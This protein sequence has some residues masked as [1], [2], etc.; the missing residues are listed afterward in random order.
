MHHSIASVWFQPVYFHLICFLYWLQLADDTTPM[1]KSEE[2]EAER[3]AAE[4]KKEEDEKKKKEA[5]KD[6]DD[7]DSDSSEVSFT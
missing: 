7:S 3:K 5:K 6:S 2:A 1:I 4:K